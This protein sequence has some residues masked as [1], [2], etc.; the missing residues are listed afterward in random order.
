[1]LRIALRDHFDA[2]HHL[3]DYPG[4]CNN[5]HGHRWVV[6]V[7]YGITPAALDA[8]AGRDAVEGRENN[9]ESH[10]VMDFS[11]L[12][13]ILHDVLQKFDHGMV[14]HRIKYP[15]AEEIAMYIWH[16]LPGTPKVTGPPG[17][18]NARVDYAWLKRPQL[19][20]VRVFE[21]P[22]AYAEYAGEKTL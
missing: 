2:A 1:M 11:R 13:A 3:P 10:M 8:C 16:E 21:T 5:I 17:A 4:P 22:D 14:N 9:P 7:S 15:T 18:P 19:L 12:K 20:Y 6:E